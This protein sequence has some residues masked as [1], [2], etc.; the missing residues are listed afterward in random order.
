MNNKITYSL[1][2]LFALVLTFLSGQNTAFA[3]SDNPESSLPSYKAGG[4]LQ[5][6][7]TFDQTEDIPPRFAIHRARIGVTGNITEQISVNFIGGFKE[8]PN[9]TPRLV[10]AFIDFDVHSILKVRTGQF[11]LPFGLEGPEP[12]FLNPAIERATATRRLNTFAMFRDIGIQ[13]SGSQSR[14][15]Y[16]VALVNG[17]GANNIEQIEPK[18]LMGRVGFILTDELRAGIS[19]HA[20]QYQP[21]GTTNDHESRF[22][23]GV[24]M[25]YESDPL[26]IRGEYIFRWDDL[27]SGDT[28]EISGGY[29]LGGFE[30]T[31]ELQTIARFEYFKP[32]TGI[33]DNHFTAFTIGANYYFIGNTRLSANYEFRNDQLN[34]E[35]N[36]LFTVQMQVAL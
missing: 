11:L 14:F 16:A 13:L 18:D 1:V 22:R 24:D 9:N 26:F 7:F 19:G 34:P 29:L 10:N 17:A 2:F 36:N 31:E 30:L 15:N 33:D 21:A 35:I 28:R 27:P 8:P 23:T 32:D 12:I 20:G 5:Q 25:R 4:F 3:Q 6:Q